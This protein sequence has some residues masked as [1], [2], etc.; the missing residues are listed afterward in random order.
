[1]MTKIKIN[2]PIT[3][4][5]LLAGMLA[6][7]NATLMLLHSLRDDKNCYALNYDALSE[8]AGVFIRELLSNFICDKA[9]AFCNSTQFQADVWQVGKFARLAP[10]INTTRLYDFERCVYDQAE[11]AD[12]NA[13]R[14]QMN[15]DDITNFCI[16]LGAM[17]GLIAIT[18]GACYFR[19]KYQAKALERLSLLATHKPDFLAHAQS[20]PNDIRLIRL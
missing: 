12:E 13:K 15:I 1:M 9:N 16:F 8:E 7:S 3:I 18:I 6:L 5:F 11:M 4:S 19:R 2:P 14:A 20:K 10:G 17:A